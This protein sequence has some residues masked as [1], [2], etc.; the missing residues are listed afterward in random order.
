MS[1]MTVLINVLAVVILIIIV[2]NASALA[3]LKFAKICLLERWGN[4][5][6]YF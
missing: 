4:S 5:A 3:K 2:V 1:A 6:Y